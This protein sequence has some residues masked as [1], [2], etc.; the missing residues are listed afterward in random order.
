MSSNT[1]HNPPIDPKVLI[2]SARMYETKYPLIILMKAA[3]GILRN[4]KSYDSEGSREDAFILYSRFV[5]LVANYM[6]NHPDLKKSKKSFK[7]D[8]NNKA[9]E[10]YYKFTLL[11]PNLSLAMGR[12]EAIIGEIKKEYDDYRKVE[13]AH[14]ELRELQKR[15]FQE[16]KEREDK[17]FREKSKIIER[18]K[19]SMHS[20]DKELFQ[21]LHSLS[22]GPGSGFD[23]LNRVEA[24]SYPHINDVAIIEEDELLPNKLSTF[25]ERSRSTMI[26][27]NTTSSNLTT[28]LSNEINHKTTNYTEGGAPLRTVFLSAELCATFTKISQSNTNKNLE[29]CGILIGKLNRN[30]FFITHLLIP[31]QDSTSDT[32]ATKN[33]ETMFEYIDN[34]D[35]D[36]FILGWIHTHPTQSCFLSSIDL[37]TQNSYQIMLNE[38]IAIVVAPSDKHKKKLGVFRLTDP[39]GIPIITNCNKS[40]FH[41]HDEPNLYVECNRINNNEV[42]TGHVVVKSGLS[43]KVKDL[44]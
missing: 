43:F 10:L 13:M 11:L 2:N 39:P 15:K 23:H 33:E 32:C 29:T 17:E 3:P 18:R 7:V 30:A 38:A 22:K 24:P 9:S 42:K 12:S 26:D 14:R 5:D 20:D 6:A 25:A 40:G 27:V 34:E 8:K 37:H 36:L 4:A 19:S 21:K 16:R 44:R 31:Q 28:L 35:P 41:P 1:Q